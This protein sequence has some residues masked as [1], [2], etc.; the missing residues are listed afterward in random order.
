MRIYRKGLK[1]EKPHV[2]KGRLF[3]LSFAIKVGKKESMAV[4]I[5]PGRTCGT[6]VRARSVGE[7]QS[8]E[9]D[10]LLVSAETVKA[11]LL[12]ERECEV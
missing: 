3:A 8:E 10:D 9:C 7:P 4:N 12:G 6:V 1:N 5:Y 11:A 2:Y